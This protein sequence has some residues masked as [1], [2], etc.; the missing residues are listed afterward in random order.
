[1]HPRFH[2]G[3][4][5][6]RVRHGCYIHVSPVAPARCV[7]GLA[8]AYDH[9]VRARALNAAQQLKVLALV[10]DKGP[11]MDGWVF[12]P[13]IPGWCKDKAQRRANWNEGPA[14]KWPQDE[15]K[16][17]RHL[18]AHKQDDL[19]FTPNTFLGE[20]R[21]AQFTGEEK[22][23][24]ADLDEVN[25]TTD[26]DR[27]LRP[28]IAWET[29]PDR[30]QAVWMLS[31]FADGATEAGGLNHRLTSM[32]GADPSGWDTTQLLR[33]PGRR[34]FK[35]GY[36]DDEGDSP[37]GRLLWVTSK[38]FD[39][40][41][42]NN[43][44]PKV[45]VYATGADIEDHEIDRVDRV[46][47]WAKARLKVSRN[48][49]DYMGMRSRQITEDFDRSEVLWQIERE[50]ADAGCTV[51]E[52][53]AIVRPTAWNKHEG[54]NNEMAQLKAEAAKAIGVALADADEDVLESATSSRSTRPTQPRWMADIVSE[55][56]ARPR[57]LIN[58]I[59]A[60]GSCGFI[61]AEPK[62]YKSYFALDMAI[63]IATGTP[64][65]NEPRFASRQGNVLFLSEEDAESLVMHRYNQII[66]QK[67]PNA[68]WRGQITREQVITGDPVKVAEGLMWTPPDIPVTMASHPRQGFLVDD[69]V[70]QIWLL[71]FIEEFG[72]E[73]VFIDTLGTTLGRTSI[74]DQELY[75][76][77]LNPLK[78]I[79]SRTGAGIAII[80]HNRKST[81]TG[82][83][84]GQQMAGL[85]AL[86]AWVDSGLYLTKGEHVT[87]QPAEI[88]VERENK[89]AQDMKFRVRIPTMFEE[90][91]HEENG[92]RQ[93]WEPEVWDGWAEE[94]DGEQAAA[95]DAAR[96]VKWSLAGDLA[97]SKGRRGNTMTTDELWAEYG[98]QR[99]RMVDMLKRDVINGFLTGNDEEGWTLA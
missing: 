58:N 80:H 64:F 87:G 56:I 33:V 76:R 40:E 74:T 13:W 30:F 81:A 59:W 68:S 34:N 36:K 45:E 20:S 51:A 98:G 66:D 69:P 90:K 71:E 92:A 77:V 2:R 48:V 14:F 46:A 78:E 17:L 27:D 63:S 86:H 61:A 67:A 70:W 42:L 94:N 15:A 41:V 72:F 18:E 16:I 22:V 75:P 52:I 1:M 12:L 50:L 28:T 9:I 88:K 73:Q 10:W 5:R 85:G 25:P 47:V 23:L 93:L 62:S 38:R 35:P 21:I 53:V 8:Y 82:G 83:R 29:S 7:S 26:I 11:E 49:L 60:R 84:A 54:R 95:K 24:Y 32:L 65:L 55:P 89:L 6:R 43:R 31:D 44:L 79:S 37:P 96:T 39:V 99:H 97:R 3:A 4:F 57:W 19:Y 91:G